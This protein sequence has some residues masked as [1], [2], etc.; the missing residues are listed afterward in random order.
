MQAAGLDVAIKAASSQK[1]ATF[2]EKQAR[3]E[4]L[5]QAELEQL[6]Q[7]SPEHKARKIGSGSKPEA[8]L[9]HLHPE[10]TSELAPEPTL[11]PTPQ[12]TPEPSPEPTPESS[13]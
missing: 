1:A 4:L 3:G 11:E 8:L 5:L 6:L 12:P 13:A 9:V 2:G 7:A 10:P